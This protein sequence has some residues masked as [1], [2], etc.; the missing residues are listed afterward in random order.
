MRELK[1]GRDEE[2]AREDDGADGAD[3]N[4]VGRAEEKCNSTC[5]VE[6][7]FFK[8]LNPCLSLSFG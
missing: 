1:G 2:E 5:Q 7:D 8:H 3:G 4:P 6:S